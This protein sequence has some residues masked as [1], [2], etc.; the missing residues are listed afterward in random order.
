MKT[1]VLV[2]LRLL[3]PR[4]RLRV[5]EQE[6]MHIRM[7]TELVLVQGL[8]HNRK[9]QVPELRNHKALEQVLRIRKALAQREHSNRCSYVP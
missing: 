2:Q 6:P 4:C 5:L 7:V 8:R 3:E 1:Q 9:A